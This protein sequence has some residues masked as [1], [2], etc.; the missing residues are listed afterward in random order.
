MV[1]GDVVSTEEKYALLLEFVQQVGGDGYVN[2]RATARDVLRQIGEKP[3]PR[4]LS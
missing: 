1:G 4:D 2:T 3:N